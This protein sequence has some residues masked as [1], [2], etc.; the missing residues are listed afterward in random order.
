[1][2]PGLPDP[3]HGPVPGNGGDP[4]R[5]AVAAGLVVEEAGASKGGRPPGELRLNGAAGVI[6]GAD[7]GS[8]HCRVSASDLAG[9]PS[10]P[11]PTTCGSPTAPPRS[12][13][14]LT[15]H[16]RA[17]CPPRESV[18]RTSAPSG[19]AS[20]AGRAQ[21]RH[22]G[23]PADHA[24]LGRVAIPE[25]FADR[26]GVPT[27]VDNDAN[28]AALGEYW[29][30]KEDSE[31]IL[32]VKSAPASAAASSAEAPC[33][34]APRAR[35]GHRPHPG[36]R[37]R[38]PAVLLRKHGLPRGRR[39]RRRPGAPAARPG[40]GGG[41]DQPGRDPAGRRRQPLRAAGRA[42]GLRKH[43]EGARNPREFLQPERDCG[44]RARSPN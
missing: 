27:L 13:G 2:H 37:R 1:V 28:L 11:L 18:P 20:R 33:T 6:L 10:R 4:D 26:Y 5:G 30:R 25:F 17:C 9:A 12:W 7:L 39:G 38:G 43:R 35:R 32:Y 24:G 15:R 34:G 22:R 42:R 29:A 40:G 3:A 41:A 23:A 21:H 16:S 31:H 44:R 19:S 14:A 8:S 36:A